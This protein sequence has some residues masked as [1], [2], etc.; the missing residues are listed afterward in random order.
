MAASPYRDPPCPGR[1][2]GEGV[3]PSLDAVISLG[4]TRR[5][6]K[7]HMV[8][9]D[10]RNKERSAAITRRRIS[11]QW[12]QQSPSQMGRFTSDDDT[13]NALLNCI[14]TTPED[15]GPAAIKSASARCNTRRI[16]YGPHVATSAWQ[17]NG[18]L[19]VGYALSFL[20]NQ[21][22]ICV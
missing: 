10:P 22:S 7:T 21:A 19:H 6:I 17:L 14:K 8:I 11:L 9:Y 3:S 4:A 2:V 12:V 20:N 16:A 1:Q 5:L 13:G 15:P 18:G